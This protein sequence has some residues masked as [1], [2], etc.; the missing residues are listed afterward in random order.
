MSLSVKT[1]LC[2]PSTAA[3]LCYGC[4]RSVEPPT[5]DTIQK[6]TACGLQFLELCPR[7]IP[8]MSRLFWNLKENTWQTS[9]NVCHCGQKAVAPVKGI[10]AFRSRYVEATCD[11]GVTATYDSYDSYNEVWTNA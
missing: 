7:C 11:C 2:D 10:R 4:F 8:G 3:M 5:I 6:A 1:L 9:V